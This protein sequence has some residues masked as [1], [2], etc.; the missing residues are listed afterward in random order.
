M[1]Q[2]VLARQNAA[3]IGARSAEWLDQKGDGAL[4]TPELVVDQRAVAMFFPTEVR[5]C[6]RVGHRI[7]I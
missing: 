5:R 4:L 1:R 3:H 7:E 6:M 2:L